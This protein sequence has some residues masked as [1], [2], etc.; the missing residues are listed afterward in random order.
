MKAV[1]IAAGN[2]SRLWPKTNMIPKTLLPFGDGTI[3]STIMH[4][5]ARA[6]IRDFV[7]ILGFKVDLIINYLRQKNSF[8]FK[9]TI[10]MNNEYNR[11]NGLSVMLAREALGNKNFIL[12][13]SD[14]IITPQAITR[15]VTTNRDKNLLLVDKRID[16]IFDIDDA[17]KVWLRGQRIEKIGKDLTDYN[18]IDCGIFKLTP[19]FFE[20]MGAQINAG[21]ESISAGVKM[22]IKDQ[23]M[24]A[25][26]MCDEEAWID[27]DTP[28]AYKYAIKNFTDI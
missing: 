27:I 24:E 2:S 14:H 22:L 1:I 6:G 12:S 9:T 5:I 13:M 20:A 7:F 21:K 16:N 11:G 19:G 8:G 18:G 26:F 25:V 28:S 3:L 17:T 23:D 15:I 10:I 4:N